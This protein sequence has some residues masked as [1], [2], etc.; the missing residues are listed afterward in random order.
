[1][2]LVIDPSIAA[3]WYVPDADM[4]K[5]LNLRFGFHQGVHELLAPDTFPAD[6]ADV[7][8]KAEQKGNILPKEAIRHVDDLQVVSVRLHPSFP[9]LARSVDLALSTHVTLHASLYIALAE[10]E[11]CQLLTADQKLIRKVRKKFSFVL[12]FAL[13]P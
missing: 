9:L 6:I 8:V 4:V 12:D 7:L 10:Q 13:F 1:M 11:N 3:K 2:K 5:A